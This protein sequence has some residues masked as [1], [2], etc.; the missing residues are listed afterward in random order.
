MF[1]SLFLRLPRILLG[2]PYG[3]KSS[4][5]TR[6]WNTV[7]E[8]AAVFFCE[9]W[10]GSNIPGSPSNCITSFVIPNYPISTGLNAP[11]ALVP[12]VNL[13]SITPIIRQAEYY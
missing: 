10:K 1:C 12:C 4:L 5:V 9:Q 11:L 7:Q 2:N 13:N 8:I 3:P 6:A